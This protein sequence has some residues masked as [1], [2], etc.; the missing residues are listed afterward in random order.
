[1]D[2]VGHSVV[3]PL[4]ELFCVFQFGWH[5]ERVGDSG[6]TYFKMQRFVEAFAIADDHGCIATK[7]EQGHG[8]VAS[9]GSTKEI[10]PTSFIT[11]GL[12]T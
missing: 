3:V 6:A 8:F 9:C 4:C 10:D 12:V 5:I 2:G 1:M 7:G 11:S